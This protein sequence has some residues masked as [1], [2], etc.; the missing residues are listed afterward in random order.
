MEHITIDQYSEIAAK[1]N[2]EIRG[3]LEG[4]VGPDSIP[5]VSMGVVKAV[6]SA[7]DKVLP[8]VE[9]LAQ[10][11]NAVGLLPCAHCG[12]EADT[13]TWC[14]EDSNWYAFCKVCLASTGFFDEESEA[15]AAWNRRAQ[16][17]NA[18]RWEPLVFDPDG[19]IVHQEMA[20]LMAE[21]QRTLLAFG[22]TSDVRLCCQRAQP[23]PS[24]SAMVGLTKE[25]AE[26]IYGLVIEGQ[27]NGMERTCKKVR[28]W[29]ESQPSPS[30]G[31]P[32]AMERVPDGAI[33]RRDDLY[34]AGGNPVSIEW[35]FGGSTLVCRY[36]SADIDPSWVMLP[37]KWQLWRPRPQDTEATDATN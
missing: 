14:S 9:T 6:L 29:L 35:E 31:Q 1:A 11:V 33:T 20:K 27:V 24:P 13:T 7:A 10:P 3:R 32:Q 16:P 4:H 12:D 22:D 26:C 5:T 25:V 2:A 34:D 8:K 19:D 18:D 17:V 28:E 23:Q 30:A 21:M 37:P 36:L 15:I